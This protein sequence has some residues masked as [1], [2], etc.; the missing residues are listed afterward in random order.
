MELTGYVKDLHSFL[1]GSIFL[2]PIRIGS[3]MRMKILDAVLAG[4]P[5]ITT[6][7]GVE[8]IDFCHKQECLIADTPEKLSTA[9]I[10]LA[11]N[12]QEQEKLAKQA[13][14]Q[15]QNLYNPSKMLVQRMNIYR[16]LAKRN[17]SCS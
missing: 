8:G 12:P 7:K 9:I 2:V 5:F 13:A 14:E 1:Q 15:L 6:T 3:G 10:H 17:T 4:I 16:Q 11:Q